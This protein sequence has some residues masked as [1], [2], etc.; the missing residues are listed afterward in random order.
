MMNGLIYKGLPF[1][2]GAIFLFG[3]FFEAASQSMGL[4]S[5]LGS[6]KITLSLTKNGELHY[7]VKHRDKI[8][9]A[10]SPLGLKSDD[11]D[12]TS[13]LSVIKVSPIEV[14]REKYD[15][16]VGNVKTINHVFERKSITFKNR[17]GALMIIDLVT[18]NEGVAFR[19]RFP[20][21]D[22]NIRVITTESTGF[23]IEKNAKGWLQ[24]Y[25]KAGKYTP[26][27]EDFY[28]KIRPGD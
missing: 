28:L 18:G 27:Y 11:Q 16:K 10:D 6:N 17:S 25:N 24:P 5:K 3:G 4:S 26:G 13:G 9:I 19:Y 14:R 20:D 2:A 15:L 7:Q 22:K 1:L 8:I 23:Q 21:Q 12:F